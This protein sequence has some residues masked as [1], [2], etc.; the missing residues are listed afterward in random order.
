MLVV[1]DAAHQTLESPGGLLA[2][3]SEFEFLGGQDLVEPLQRRGVK[4]VP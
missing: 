3:F 4:S 2:S 1:Y